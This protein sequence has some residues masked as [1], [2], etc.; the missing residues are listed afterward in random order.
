MAKF[1]LII[2]TRISHS[3]YTCVR[4]E[5]EQTARIY[6]YSNPHNHLAT[7]IINYDHYYFSYCHNRHY[8]SRILT[9]VI[10]RL[11]ISVDYID[12]HIVV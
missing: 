12:I 2:L 6:H 4:Q 7:A 1:F 3:A 11:V 5:I 8:E 10:Y 9:M